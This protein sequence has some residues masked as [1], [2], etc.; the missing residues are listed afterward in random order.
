MDDNDY[1]EE[2]TNT[3][4]GKK[5][6]TLTILI[7]VYLVI[8]AFALIVFWLIS[9]PSDA[10]AYSLMFLWFLLPVTTF[11]ISLLLG[12]NG[13][14]GKRRWFATVAFGV[15]YMLAEYATYSLANMISNSFSKINMPDF[16]MVLIGAIISAVGM[17]IG[18]LLSRA[19]SDKK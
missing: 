17:G 7:A 9:A 8:W 2:S 4:K 14:W 3:V 10:M 15:M 11:V 1:L 16:K 5:K 18:V 19:K 6:L 12:K 13:F